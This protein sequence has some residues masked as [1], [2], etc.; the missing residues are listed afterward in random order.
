MSVL[1][2]S[3]FEYV[4]LVHGVR[5]KAFVATIVLGRGSDVPADASVGAKGGASVSGGVRYDTCARRG[6]GYTIE[7]KIA[8][9]GGMC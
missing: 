7:V 1:E 2:K 3:D 5:E 9:D 8:E 6:Q 4:G